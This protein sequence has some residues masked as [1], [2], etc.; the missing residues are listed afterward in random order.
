MK[1]VFYSEEVFDSFYEWMSSDKKIAKRIAAL[2]KNINR[3][4]F[5][6]IGKPEPLK[7]GLSGWW[8]REINSEHRLVYKVEGEGDDKRLV[9]LSCKY[10]Y[11]S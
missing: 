5:T 10:H 2:I 3:E 1:I 6:G 4:P 8:S 9:V 11:D 7:H